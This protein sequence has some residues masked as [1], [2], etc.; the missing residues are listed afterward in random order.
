MAESCC[1]ARTGSQAVSPSVTAE[2][3]AVPP[4]RDCRSGGDGLGTSSSTSLLTRGIL[5][6]SATRARGGAC[7][8]AVLFIIALD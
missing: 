7:V 8:D 6:R 3:A 5:D 1:W 2:N 4:C